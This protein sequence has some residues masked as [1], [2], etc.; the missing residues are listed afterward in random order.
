VI[1]TPERLVDLA[2]TRSKLFVDGIEGALK[3]DVT[4]RS[5]N[6]NPTSRGFRYSVG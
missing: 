2:E 6:V 3:D 4:A 1:D 5:I